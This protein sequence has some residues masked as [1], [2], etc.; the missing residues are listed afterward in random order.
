VNTI[1]PAVSI[2]V[3]VRNAE[4]TVRDCI[5]S[6]LQLEYP[7]TRREVIV[8]DNGSSDATLSIIRG[9]P[10]KLVTEPRRGPSWA[11][12]AG[13]NASGGDI[14]AFTDADCIAG[15]AWLRELVAGFQED[16]GAW[17]V[18]GEVL[19]FAPETRAEHYMARRQDRWQAAALR[20]PRP[21]MVTANVAF[22]RQ[23]FDKIGRFDPR[24]PIGQDQ[25]LSWRFFAAGLRCRYAPTAIVFHRHRRTTW[26]FFKQQLGWGYGAA[27]LRRHHGLPWGIGAE[28][29]ELRQLARAAHL[30]VAAASRAALGAAPQAET[31]YRF[32]D[33]LREAARR[34]GSVRAALEYVAV[35]GWRR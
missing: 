13:I 25:D 28:L 26:A 6:L 16:D 31:A 8:V 27:L 3:P 18:A 33:F 35:R 23:T 12:N 34:A 14:I 17:A 7:E 24:F 5:A 32:H 9:L 15:T 11:R 30:L 10:V 29:R 1:D 19:A 4:R 22:R 20:A 2:V 21:Y